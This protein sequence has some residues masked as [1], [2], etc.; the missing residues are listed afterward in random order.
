MRS[1]VGSP[2]IPTNWSLVRLGVLGENHAF[3]LVI[4]MSWPDLSQKSNKILP[5][6]L[7]SRTVALVKRKISSAKNRCERRTRP[8]KDMGWIALSRIASFNLID[9]LSRQRMKR[10]GDRGSPCLM[11]R[12]GITSG[13]WV[14]FQRMWKRV[15]VTIFMMRVMR[16]GGSWKNSRVSWIKCHSSRS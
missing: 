1:V 13:K 2:R 9:N 14:P 4:L 12:L 6:F 10:Y 11:P 5:R 8:L 15:E 3:D 16:V 7:Q